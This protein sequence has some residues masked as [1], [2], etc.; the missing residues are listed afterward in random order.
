MN[1]ATA[2][3]K[4]LAFEI[5]FLFSEITHTQKRIV[6]AAP[7]QAAIG[8]TAVGKTAATPSTNRTAIRFLLFLSCSTTNNQTFRKLDRGLG[9]M[10]CSFI[11]SYGCNQFATVCVFA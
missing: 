7:M 1:V 4:K 10:V 8:P 3:R 9:C 5:S 6:A 11:V 2:D